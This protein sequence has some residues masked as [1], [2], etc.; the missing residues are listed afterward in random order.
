MAKKVPDT[1]SGLS[2]HLYR[3]LSVSYMDVKMK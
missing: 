3:L 1:F 2:D